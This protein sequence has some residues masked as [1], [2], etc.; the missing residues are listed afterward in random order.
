MADAVL[1]GP[2]TDALRRVRRHSGVPLA[3]GGVVEDA[4]NL[5]LKHFV[6]TTV[7][8]LDGV[9]VDVGHGLGGK[10]IAL[11]RP[12]VVDDY[13]KTPRITHRYNQI[14]AA[15]GLRAMAAAP[16]IVDRSP[17]AVLYGALHT[18]DPIGDRTLQ[19]LATEARAV[20]QQV[21]AARAVVEH[22]GRTPEVS[23]LRD[24]LAG[25]YA[26][27]RLVARELD[28]A[29]LADQLQRI[30]DSL[31]DGAR[32][33]EQPTV[34]LT[35]REVDVLASVALGHSNARIAET[36]GV[37]AMTV[38]GYVKDAMRKLDASTRLEAV[39]RARAVGILP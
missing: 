12:I 6:G 2:L 29:E 9:A 8:A 28:D 5:R 11:N 22:D 30:S 13:L 21:V 4:A 14:I 16:V 31:L 37:T 20:E 3:F 34:S 26:Q 24:R 32:S 1:R 38:K 27:L 35:A 25:A 19:V 17:I 10:V 33:T 18:T 7:G 36:L 15:E 23:A 39:V